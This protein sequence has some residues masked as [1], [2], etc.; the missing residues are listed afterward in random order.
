[1]IR[2]L[3]ALSLCCAA[4]PAFADA[5]PTDVPVQLAMFDGP[6]ANACLHIPDPPDYGFKVMQ[7]QCLTVGH[8]QMF[9]FEPAVQGGYQIRNVKSQGCL[10]AEPGSAPGDMVEAFTCDG[11]LSQRWDVNH[12]EGNPGNAMIRSQQTGMCLD[13]SLGVAAQTTCSFGL[14]QGPTWMVSRQGARVPSGAL[15]MR[16]DIDGQCMSL[17]E[18]PVSVA[19][20]NNGRS[21]LRFVPVDAAATTFR[22]DGPVDGTCLMDGGSAVVYDTCIAGLNSQWRIVEAGFESPA[23]IGEM[24]AF[25]Q[26]QNVGTGQCLHARRGSVVPEGETVTA[27]ACDASDNAKWQF[28]KY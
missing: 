4:L 25:W 27:W 26:V 2:S 24:R 21:N 9:Q 10:N 20:S 15:A 18:F 11:A 19:C 22:F 23:P 7:A 28:V 14:G 6:D 16:S 17:D 3:L 1:M 5:P 12:S 13:F 8:G